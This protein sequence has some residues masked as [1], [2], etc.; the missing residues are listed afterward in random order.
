MHALLQK[1]KHASRLVWF[2]VP[3]SAANFATEI[4]TVT[5]ENKIVDETYFNSVNQAALGLVLTV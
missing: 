3:D 5:D 4:T 1:I 2:F